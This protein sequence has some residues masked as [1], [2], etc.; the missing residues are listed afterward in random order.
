MHEER[1]KTGKEKLQIPAQSLCVQ[2]PFYRKL[3]RSLA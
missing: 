2:D 1:D 3:V